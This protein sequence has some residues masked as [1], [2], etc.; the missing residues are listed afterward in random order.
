[1]NREK[2]KE[3]KILIIALLL[4]VIFSAC[5]VG[6]DYRPHIMNV[7]VKWPDVEREGD[8]TLQAAEAER[9]AEW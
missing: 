9:L 6:P 2:K 3:N 7:P 4:C 5:Q 1:M 8:R